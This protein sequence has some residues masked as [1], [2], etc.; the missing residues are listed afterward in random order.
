MKNKSI[1]GISVFII[2]LIIP[3]IL[4]MFLPA[5]NKCTKPELFLYFIVY[6]AVII[7]FLSIYR[8]SLSEDFKKIKKNKK[9]FFL[10]I[11][12]CL[13][14]S[15]VTM[16]I[17]S[18]I[19][20]L[21]VGKN[22]DTNDFAV[23]TLFDTIPAFM[24]FNTLIYAPIVEEIV[25]RKTFYDI[26][27]NKTFFVIFSAIVF[28]FYHI[29]YNFVALKEFA[30]MIPYIFMGTVLASSYIKTKSI[31]APITV[32]FLYNLIILFVK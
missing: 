2:Y 1:V 10:T 27:D 32:H 19:S 23:N 17:G 20:S 22:T 24:L 26:L 15:F 8:K 29:G 30:N 18:I 7:L 28:G 5:L 25:F 21:I 11:I 14:L 9:N 3:M 6:A 4:N 31:Y 13:I 16:A 12:I